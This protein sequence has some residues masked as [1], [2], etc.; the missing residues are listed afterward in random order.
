VIFN[1]IVHEENE[2]LSDLNLR[3]IATLAPLLV[4]VFW[5]GFYPDKFL[6]ILNAS[7]EHLIEPLQTFQIAMK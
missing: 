6:N 1:P 2:N 7:V 3:E 5:I 4:L